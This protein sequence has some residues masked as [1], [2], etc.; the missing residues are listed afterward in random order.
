MAFF[1]LICVYLNKLFSMSFSFP[2]KMFLMFG[3]SFGSN[4]DMSVS[5]IR[6]GG[7]EPKPPAVFRTTIPY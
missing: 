2:D 6:V 3:S 7:T 1:V 4:P 5:T